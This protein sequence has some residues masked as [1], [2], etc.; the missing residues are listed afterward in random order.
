MRDVR[1]KLYAVRMYAA[2]INT[3][4]RIAQSAKCWATGWKTE[5]FGVNCQQE[6]MM[7]IHPETVV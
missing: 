4:A 6:H 3:T 1:V 5:E 7:S 2:K